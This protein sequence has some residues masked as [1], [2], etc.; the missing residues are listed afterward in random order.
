MKSVGGLR[1][2]RYRRRLRV[3]MHAYLAGAAYNLVRSASLSPAPVWK[4][5]L[6]TLVPRLQTVKP[7]N[8]CR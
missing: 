7:G 4:P 1:R 8:L 6:Q 5:L 3:Q 2:M